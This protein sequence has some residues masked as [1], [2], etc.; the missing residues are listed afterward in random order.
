MVATAGKA[1]QGCE[2]AV[3]GSRTGTVDVPVPKARDAVNCVKL[4][5]LQIN[6]LNNTFNKFMGQRPLSRHGQ[7]PGGPPPPHQDCSSG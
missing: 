2:T 3:V 5:R 7:L 4:K 1:G 6:D